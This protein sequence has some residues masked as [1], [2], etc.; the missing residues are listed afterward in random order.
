M[1]FFPTYSFE[2][3][4]QG[5]RRCWRFGREGPVNVNV[6]SAPGESRVMD[7]L[8]RKQRKA[9]EMFA[10]LIV[11]MNQAVELNSID[12]HTKEME[13]PEWLSSTSL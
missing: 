13:K 7:G 8:E 1:T 3:V 2:Q 9:M 6:I 4:Y 5:I 10:A 12:Q 11:H